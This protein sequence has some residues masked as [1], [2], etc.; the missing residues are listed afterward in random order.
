MAD[1]KPKGNAKVKLDGEDILPPDADSSD[2]DKVRI[3]IEDLPTDDGQKAA[4]DIEGVLDEEIPK[5][6]EVPPAVQE[7]PP[8][9]PKAPEPGKPARKLWISAARLKKLPLLKIAAI[10]GGI[11]VFFL[12]GLLTL[13]LLVRQA[14]LP[15][16]EEQETA[17]VNGEEADNEATDAGITLELEPFVVP[18]AGGAKGFL[19]LTVQ[20]RAARGAPEAVRREN[21]RVR[22]TI[23]NM[24]LH[25]DAEAIMDEERRTMIGSELKKLLNVVLREEYILE[26]RFNNMVV[27]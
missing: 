6:L 27:V 26:V 23:Y 8:K 10:A 25:T 7:P 21:V 11:I 20:L 22:T 9:P 16:E 14:P 5:E 15:D 2:P 1:E 17:A 18:V 19:R 12:A 4:L 24:L 13:L 3:D